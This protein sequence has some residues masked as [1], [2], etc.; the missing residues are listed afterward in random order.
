[1]LKLWWY[2]NK[3]FV[4]FF[5]SAVLLRVTVGTNGEILFFDETLTSK[6]LIGRDPLWGIPI[7]SADSRSNESNLRRFAAVKY[8]GDGLFK[9]IPI[10]FL[11]QKLLKLPV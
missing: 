9:I 6:F 8:D 4:V 3:P 10:N 7:S 1:M 2:A 5:S 11:F